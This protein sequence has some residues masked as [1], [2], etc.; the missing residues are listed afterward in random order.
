[1][2]YLKIAG[3]NFVH[4]PRTTPIIRPKSVTIGMKNCL[5]MNWYQFG[6]IVVQFYEWLGSDFDLVVDK[7]PV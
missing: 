6:I 7:I 5:V 2:F 1:L 3:A 4:A